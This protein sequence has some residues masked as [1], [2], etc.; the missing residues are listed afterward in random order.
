MGFI[1]Q[2]GLISQSLYYRFCSRNQATYCLNI[3]NIYIQYGELVSFRKKKLYILAWSS[4]GDNK[5]LPFQL[6]IYQNI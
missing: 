4:C 6:Y 1:L 2:N 3:Y 5:S